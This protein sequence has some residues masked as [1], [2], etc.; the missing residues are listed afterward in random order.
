MD[1]SKYSGGNFIKVTDVQDGPIQEQIAVVKLGKWDKPN[2]VFESGSMLSV[3]STNNAVLMKAYGKNSD[4]WLGKAVELYLGQIEFQNQ[5]QEAVLVRPISPPLSPAERTK[6]VSTRPTVD[7]NDPLPA[8][9]KARPPG[10][11]NPL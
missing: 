9:L 8:H 5:P 2:L 7:Y 4:D 10:D 3:N 6:P 1:M 11:E